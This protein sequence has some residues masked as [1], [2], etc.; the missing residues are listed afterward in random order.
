MAVAAH[1]VRDD[2]GRKV[3]FAAD[4]LVLTFGD[5]MAIQEIK[6][7][8]HGKL[9]STAAT[10]RTT[11]TGEIIDLQF[12]PAAH[13]STFTHALAMQKAVAE[14][15]P[16]QQ[17]GEAL[18]ET[19]VMRSEVIHLQMR[20]GG[21]EIDKVETDG[22]GT[23]EFLPNR[24]GQPKRFVQGDRIWITYGPENR[25]QSFLAINVSPALKSPAAGSTAHAHAEQGATGDIRS[26]NQRTHA[27][28]SDHGFP[29]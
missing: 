17:S 27:P 7:Q 2:P 6:G 14:A 26:Q 25:I 10:M 21:K 3:E 9:V 4:S 29:L 11:V 16:L 1:G 18:A 13:E 19:R 24:P 12:D 5:D 20:P 28:G 22:A 8:Q 23:V 15:Q